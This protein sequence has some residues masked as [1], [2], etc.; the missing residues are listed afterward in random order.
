MQ[1]V[2][3][4]SALPRVIRYRT[5]INKQVMNNCMKSNVI[6]LKYNWAPLNKPVI[7]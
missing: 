5:S 2:F 1:Y 4:L 3:W 7:I 6:L